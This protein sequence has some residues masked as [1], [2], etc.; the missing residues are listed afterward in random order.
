MLIVR[1]SLPALSYCAFM[2]TG[3]KSSLPWKYTR[4]ISQRLGCVR[5]GLDLVSNLMIT[6][7]VF[8]SASCI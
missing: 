2:S 4:T 1:S 7:F 6:A 8:S 5:R 3:M